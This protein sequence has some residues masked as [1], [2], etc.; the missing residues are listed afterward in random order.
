MK[1][2]SL[3]WLVLGVLFA[4]I[5]AVAVLQLKS[6]RSFK[7]ISGSNSPA[8]PLA[9]IQSFFEDAAQ[10]RSNSVH[11]KLSRLVE[12]K[13]EV[14]QFLCDHD[15]GVWP[16]MPLRMDGPP[17][18]RSDGVIRVRLVVQENEEDEPHV[19]PVS[20]TV[21]RGGL[22][23]YQIGGMSPYSFI[24]SPRTR[25]SKYIQV[26]TV[27]R[28]R[29]P[30]TTGMNGLYRELQHIQARMGGNYPTGEELR[31][32]SAIA[33]KLFTTDK[34]KKPMCIYIEGQSANSP[35]AN[36]LAYEADIPEGDT[37]LA[38]LCSGQVV[39]YTAG[40]MIHAVNR[41]KANLARR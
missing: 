9:F 26:V 28:Q 3:I 22:R 39:R 15:P 8:D 32:Y 16:L 21:E 11:D 5:A 17:E 2:V 7:G 34:G 27:N 24:A 13:A 29:G 1:K 14:V 35:P 30:S 37:G 20:L 23:L 31:K 38:L 40:D 12:N 18:Q 6:N 25:P 36:I 41:T 4:G 33:N 19:L 10:C